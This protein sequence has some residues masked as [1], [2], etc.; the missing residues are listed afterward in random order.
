MGWD[1]WRVSLTNA[2]ELRGESW[3]DVVSHTLTE[4]ELDEPW[5]NY[6]M[7]A[8]F[9]L[10]TTNTVYFPMQ[11][12]SQYWAGSAPRYPDGKPTKYQ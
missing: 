10:W 12:D 8:A 6:G 5:G 7:G 1:N 3:K 2:M 11:Y 9:T 4:Q